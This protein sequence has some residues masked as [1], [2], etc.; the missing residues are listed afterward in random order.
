MDIIYIDPNE[1]SCAK[2]DNIMDHI[3]WQRDVSFVMPDHAVLTTDGL[4]FLTDVEGA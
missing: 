3:A 2:S 4:Y 1:V